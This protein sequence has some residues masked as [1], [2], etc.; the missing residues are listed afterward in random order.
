MTAKQLIS[1][2]RQG[3]ETVEGQVHSE[4]PLPRVCPVAVT[5]LPNRI[6]HIMRRG[7]SCIFFSCFFFYMVSVSAEPKD[8]VTNT[9]MFRLS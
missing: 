6:C 4:I 5:T 2:L 9:W 3:R 1:H 8:H 7:H